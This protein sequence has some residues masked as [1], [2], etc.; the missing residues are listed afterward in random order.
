CHGSPL[1]LAKTSVLA[2]NASLHAAMLE[3][4]SR[5]CPVEVN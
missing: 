5:H 2:T 3:I 1:P 4:V